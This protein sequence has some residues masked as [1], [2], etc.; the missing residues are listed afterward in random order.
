MNS[1]YGPYVPD[2]LFRQFRRRSLPCIALCADGDDR[3]CGR[4]TI[5]RRTFCPV[6]LSGRFSGFRLLPGPGPT[7][8]LNG[9]D[10]F[11]GGRFEPSS[12]ACTDHDQDTQRCK[13]H[14]RGSYL[15]A[16]ASVANVSRW[17]SKMMTL[18][19]VLRFVTGRMIDLW[20]CRGAAVECASLTVFWPSV[21]PER[22]S[23]CSSGVAH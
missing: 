18:R 7:R 8:H 12:A 14:V 13:Q 2:L 3:C 19:C 23:A 10:L 16:L 5:F 6:R 21:G 1:S 4:Q 11:A 17:C 22:P 20:F 15:A 9:T